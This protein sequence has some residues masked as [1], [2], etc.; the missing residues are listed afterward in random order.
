MAIRNGD[1]EL[2]SEL[3]RHPLGEVEDSTKKL[4]NFFTLGAHPNRGLIPRRFLGEGNEFVLGS[5]GVPSLALI[6]E[7]CVIHLRMWFWFTATLLHFYQPL[8]DAAKPDFGSRYL[9][10]ANVAQKLQITL[11]Q[12]YDRLLSEEQARYAKPRDK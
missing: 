9:C 6:T 12:N 2:R 1:S 4:Y 5:V 11:D 10:V 7:Y 8:I 3:A